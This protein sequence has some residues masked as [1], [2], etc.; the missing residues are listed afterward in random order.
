[1]PSLAQVLGDWTLEP[2]PVLLAVLAL[3]VYGWA[4]LRAVRRWPPVRAASFAAGVAAVLLALCSGLDGYGDR[5]LSIHMV[6]HLV[7]TLV[8]PPLLIVGRPLELTL[9]ALH[10]ERRRAL[11]RMLSGRTARW[12]G[13]PAV[14]WSAF[15]AVM[16]GSHLPP[17]YQAAVRHDPLHELE[18]ALYLASAL[19]FWWPLLDADPHSRRQ[20]GMV[21]RLLYV[22]L[23]MPVMGVIGV[24]LQQS[25]SLVYP[26]YAQP[27]R[28][29]HVSALGDQ[30]RAGALMWVGA[31]AFM[32][33]AALLVAWLALAGEEE[34]ARRRESYEDAELTL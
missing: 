29:L 10:G 33:A 9:R 23:A 8:A 12:L 1:M 16:L 19:L 7:L 13:T 25:R 21:G 24:A 31:T 18:H 34:R 20:L 2:V 5:L 22:M 28:A 6:Q 4:A 26:V 3:G 14:A 17:V 27:G 32:A 15:A 30:V 11:A